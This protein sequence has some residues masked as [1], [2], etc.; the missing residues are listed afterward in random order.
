MKAEKTP[1]HSGGEKK[2]RQTTGPAIPTGAGRR[3][4]VPALVWVAFIVLSLFL[5]GCARFSPLYAIYLGVSL[6]IAAG[7]LLFLKAIY[8]EGKTKLYLGWKKFT[9]YSLPVY[10][11]VH[12]LPRVEWQNAGLIGA[13]RGTFIFILT[14]LATL[15]GSFAFFLAGRTVTL[16]ALGIISPEELADPALRKKRSKEKKKRGLIG[17]ILDWIDALAWAAI[18]VLLVNIFIFQLYV[19]PSE[20][21]VPAFLVGD[22]PFTLKIAAG[23][24]IPLTE[25][26]LPFLRLPHRGDVITIANPRYPENHR[27]DLKKYLSQF[28]YMITFTGVN[29]DSTLPDGTPKADP[30]VKRVVGVPGDQL[31]M[32]DDVLYAR[33]KGEKTFRKLEEPWARVDLW[34]ESAELRSHIQ[35]MPIDATTRSLLS[36]LDAKKNSVDPTLLSQ[37]IASTF[38]RIEGRID[39]AS[40]SILAAFSARELPRAEASLRPRRDE[41]IAAAAGQENP[42]VTGGAATEDLA[43]ALA[44]AESTEVRA[45]LRAYAEGAIATAAHEPSNDYERGSRALNLLI[46]ANLLERIDRD[47]ALLFGGGDIQIFGADAERVRLVAEAR[48]LYIYL[49][50]FYDSRNFPAFP[51][52]DAFLGPDEYFAMGDNRYNSLDFRFITT[53]SLRTLDPA[54]PSSVVYSSILT[55]FP[56]KLQFI[57]G[58]ALFR[59]WPPSRLGRIK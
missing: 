5:T 57:E 36:A 48:D 29:L 27:V 42:F 49:Q 30:L 1:K 38:S 46:K 37:S 34:K 52:G 23:P 13:S 47:L 32:V 21:M 31:M 54:D 11:F 20:S 53:Q 2:E 14:L 45:A 24:R 39:R 16:S 22:R 9:G 56:L 59:L 55:P 15:A 10:Y 6:L 58:Y 51:E 44:V 40:P 18:A 12:A 26:R 8:R 41:A 19:V 33:R 28:V 4:L 17:G 50:A 25:W 7:E 35:S 3:P 43:L